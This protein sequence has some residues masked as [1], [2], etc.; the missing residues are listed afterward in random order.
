MDLPTVTFQ[1]NIQ[2][3]IFSIPGPAHYPPSSA[4]YTPTCY[5]R[6]PVFFKEESSAF[7]PWMVRRTKGYYFYYSNL[8]I[9]CKTT[10]L[11]FRALFDVFWTLFGEAPGKVRFRGDL[12]G[13]HF[14]WEI[15]ARSVFLRKA[16]NFETPFI[17]YKF[18]TPYFTK[19]LLQGLLSNI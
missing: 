14:L 17:P 7:Q 18:D 4:T 9:Y 3:I 2:T 13:G 6:K 15:P 10:F 11:Y 19:K 1:Q 12:G 16:Q 5:Y 8:F